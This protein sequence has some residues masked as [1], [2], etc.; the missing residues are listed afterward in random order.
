[1]TG[2]EIV[3]IIN[4]STIRTLSELSNKLNFLFPDANGFEI[5]NKKDLGDSGILGIG[6][7]YNEKETIIVKGFLYLTENWSEETHGYVTAKNV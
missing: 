7:F 2:L 6:K 5:I 4:H 3:N 1:M